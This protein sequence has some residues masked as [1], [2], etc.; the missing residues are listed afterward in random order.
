MSRQLC[1][2]SFAYALDCF[3]GPNPLAGSCEKR[4]LLLAMA[5]D[6]IMVLQLA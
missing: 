3:S 6:T 4:M 5:R 2:Q 1:V